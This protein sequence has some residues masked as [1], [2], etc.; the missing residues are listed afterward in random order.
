MR[1]KVTTNQQNLCALIDDFSHNLMRLAVIL[2]WFRLF[3]PPYLQAA[4]QTRTK[5][6]SRAWSKQEPKPNQTKLNQ[7]LVSIVVVGGGVGFGLG[8]GVV[9]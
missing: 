7:S 6:I 1:R 2:V 9:V 8:I 5:H 3:E 4:K